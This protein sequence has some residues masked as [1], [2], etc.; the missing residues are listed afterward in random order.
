L[1]ESCTEEDFQSIKATE[2]IKVVEKTNENF[3]SARI[4]QNLLLPK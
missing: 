4:E 3:V 1:S 2:T